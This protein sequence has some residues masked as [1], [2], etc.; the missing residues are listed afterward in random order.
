MT[1]EELK[2][3]KDLEATM[4][5]SKIVA[6]EML[7]KEAI[8]WINDWEEKRESNLRSESFEELTEKI[9]AFRGF[10]NITEEEINQEKNE[11]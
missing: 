10:F 1:N 2:T 6:S 7:R 11:K 3:L 8:K 5:F 4:G 9:D